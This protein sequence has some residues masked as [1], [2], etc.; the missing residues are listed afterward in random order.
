MASAVSLSCV[1]GRKY[2]SENITGRIRC[3]YTEAMEK[4]FAC[5]VRPDDLSHSIEVKLKSRLNQEGYVLNENTPATIFVIGG[6]GT[7]LRAVHQYKKQRD[8]AVFYGIHTGTLGFY[9]DYTAADF[10]I[11]IDHFLNQRGTVEEFPLLVAETETRKFCA[12]NEVRIENAV[13]TQELDIDIDGSFFERFRGTG[14]LVATQLGST[15]YSRSL[16]GAVVQDGLNVMEM[17]EIAGIHHSRYRSLGA[18]LILKADSVITLH[19]PDLSGALLGADT[20]VLHLEQEHSVR[21]YYSDRGIKVL[22]GM[23]VSYLDRLHSL[24]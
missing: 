10:D 9:S 11:W 7:F 12:V 15:A 23:N 19:S 2:G 4:T 17:V 16:G 24:F 1:K 20:R 5:V 18:P 22:R 8:T 14:I 3:R 13:R 6:D 21:I